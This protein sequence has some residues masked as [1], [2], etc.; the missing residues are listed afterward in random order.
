MNLRRKKHKLCFSNNDFV[1]NWGTSTQGKSLS[2]LLLLKLELLE[3][4]LFP[5]KNE[6]FL[7]RQILKALLVQENKVDGKSSVKLKRTFK[8]LK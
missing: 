7:E 8:L 5:F 2:M 3:T 1:F 6:R 4:T